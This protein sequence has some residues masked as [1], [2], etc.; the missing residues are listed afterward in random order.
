M[1]IAQWEKGPPW[2]IVN[3]PPEKSELECGVPNS[4]LFPRISVSALSICDILLTTNMS[5]F[6]TRANSPF[7]AGLDDWLY[8]SRAF[9]NSDTK[10]SGSADNEPAF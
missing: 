9:F 7:V 8:L 5:V 2:R 6:A 10:N 3:V 4:N 1:I